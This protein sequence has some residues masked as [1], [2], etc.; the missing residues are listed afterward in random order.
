MILQ[1]V[2]FFSPD[3]HS[4][5]GLPIRQAATIL[6]HSLHVPASAGCIHVLLKEHRADARAAGILVDL[7][8]FGITG[9]GHA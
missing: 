1:D 4:R 2:M 9:T 6:Y 8:C 3:G 5:Y 7:H